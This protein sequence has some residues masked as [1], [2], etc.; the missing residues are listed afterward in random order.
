MAASYVGNLDIKILLYPN[1]EFNGVEAH[2]SCI[3]PI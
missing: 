3:V 1:D 2:V